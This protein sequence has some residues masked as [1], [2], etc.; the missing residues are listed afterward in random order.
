MLTLQGCLGIKGLNPE[1]IFTIA[2]FLNKVFD[3]PAGIRYRNTW[4]DKQ[5]HDRQTEI[6]VEMVI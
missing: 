5:M 1:G 2:I 3:L 6:E 4:T